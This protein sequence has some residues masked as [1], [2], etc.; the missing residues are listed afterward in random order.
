MYHIVGEGP[1]GTLGAHTFTCETWYNLL[2]V[3]SPVKVFEI[4][5]RSALK[6]F[7]GIFGLDCTYLCTSKPS[8][9]DKFLKNALC[10]LA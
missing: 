9:P 10:F 5:V 4:L 6:L 8:I 7:D 1:Y 2:Q 3:T